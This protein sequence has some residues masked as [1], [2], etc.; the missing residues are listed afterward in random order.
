MPV[1]ETSENGSFLWRVRSP[2][3]IVA[4]VVVVVE[5]TP[6]MVVAILL[7]CDLFIN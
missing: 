1:G 6:E 7:S 4:V 2:V 3:C 5:F